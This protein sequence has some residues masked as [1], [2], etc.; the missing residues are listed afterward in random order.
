MKQI[1]ELVLD[2][3]QELVCGQLLLLYVGHI[4][5][6][7]KE[8]IQ[9]SDSYYNVFKLVKHTPETGKTNHSIQ[10]V[11]GPIFNVV[12]SYICI[13]SSVVYRYTNSYILWYSNI[14]TGLKLAATLQLLLPQSPVPHLH[15]NYPI[16]DRDHPIPHCVLQWHP[17]PCARPLA[18]KRLLWLLPGGGGGATAQHN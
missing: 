8:D 17:V 10:W 18:H 6:V 7:L 9:L 13:L 15:C 3:L 4:G 5:A 16:P 14:L 2:S 1:R 12:Y 11:Q